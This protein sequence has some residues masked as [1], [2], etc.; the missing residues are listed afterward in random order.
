MNLAHHGDVRVT[1]MTEA[2]AIPD[3]ALGVGLEMKDMDREEMWIMVGGIETRIGRPKEA[4]T[5]MAHEESDSLNM[6]MMKGREIER[7]TETGIDTEMILETETAP[8]DVLRHLPAARV[9]TQL[10][11]LHDHILVQDRLLPPI[12]P[13]L[14]S[15]LLGFWPQLQTQ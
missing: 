14:T 8:L 4:G 6:D 10:G 9:P 11:L 15:R 13:S 5:S 7:G 2:M 12:K 3:Q 1:Q